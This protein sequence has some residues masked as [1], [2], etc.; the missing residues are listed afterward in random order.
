MILKIAD[1]FRLSID[2][3]RVWTFLEH[4]RLCLCGTSD[5]FYFTGTLTVC[6]YRVGIQTTLKRKL[7]WLSEMGVLLSKEC[8]GSYFWGVGVYCVG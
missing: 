3:I 2:L 1:H 5:C 6:S 8:Q 7:T 4:I